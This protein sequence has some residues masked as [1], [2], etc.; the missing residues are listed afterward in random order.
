MRSVAIW[1][2]AVS[3]LALTACGQAGKPAARAEAKAAAASAGQQPPAA[4]A[5][6]GAGGPRAVALAPGAEP[7][8][9]ALGRTAGRGAAAHAVEARLARSRGASEGSVD[10]EVDVEAMAAEMARASSDVREHGYSAAYRACTEAAHGFTATIADC[11]NTELVRQSERL[12]RALEAAVAAR[13]GDQ[14][15]RLLVTQRAWVELRDAKCRD[16]D[17]PDLLHE[18]SCRLDLTIRR[19]AELERRAG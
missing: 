2:S 16:G 12:N 6:G 1:L 13:S 10:D 5:S 19:A 15:R 4:S 14:K 8:P 18:G 3:A 7:A 11:Y 17:G 9:A